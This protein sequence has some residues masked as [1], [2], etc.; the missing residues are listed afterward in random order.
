MPV[1]G[2]LCRPSCAVSEIEFAVTLF[3]MLRCSEQLL[4]AGVQTIRVA[5]LTLSNYRNFKRMTL[6]LEPGLTVFYGANGQGKS[7]LL[8]AIYLLSVARSSRT[9]SD[10]SLVNSS[11][12]PNDSHAQVLTV[13]KEGDIATQVQIDFEAATAHTNLEGITDGK[14]ANGKIR[15]TLRV[16]GLK[17][18]AAEFVGAL[19]AV[20]FAAEDIALVMGPP[21][22]RRKYLDILIS[23]GDVTY[24][25]TLQ[26]YAR[27]VQQRNHLLRRIRDRQSGISELA[28][29]DER[30]IEEGTSIFER[31][32]EAV[33]QVTSYAQDAHVRLIGRS[34]PLRIRYKPRIGTQKLS[35]YSSASIISDAFSNGV[36]SVK[37]KELSRGISL[38][39]PHR[40]E[41]VF[42]L[43]ENVAAIYASRGQARTIAL[44]LKLAEARFITKNTKRSP[45]LA[46]DDVLSELDELRR[47]LVLEVAM[48]YEQTLV[49]TTDLDRVEQQV[50]QRANCWHISA[51][52][53]SPKGN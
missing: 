29:W 11:Q 27:V 50:L 35:Q 23:Q 1:V 26:R 36:E 13:A 28:F 46:L 53:I 19:N 34:E 16:N 40:D 52:K 45:I 4:V 18:T 41:L 48:E 38:I 24:F 12:F 8:E 10:Q 37:Q 39:G 14:L 33:E 32:F 3:R 7:N 6:D 5:R 20:S 15:K 49:T 42:G 44:A 25:R 21:S 17:C 30:L 51:G 22:T 47:R 2:E 9:T 31:R 43:G